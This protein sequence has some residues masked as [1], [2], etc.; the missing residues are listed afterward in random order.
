M[1]AD[2]QMMKGILEGCILSIIAE[3]KSYGYRV[4]EKLGNFGFKDVA[5]ATVYPILTR[6]EKKADLL[7]EKKPSK[8]GPPRK[9]YSITE[10]GKQALNEFRKSWTKTSGI[11]ENVLKGVER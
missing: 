11:V 7:S 3:E 8:L 2:T 10:Q 5:E 1:A 4:V 9:Y 6:L